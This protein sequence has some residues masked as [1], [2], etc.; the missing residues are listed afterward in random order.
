MFS[1]IPSRANSDYLSLLTFSFMAVSALA[2]EPSLKEACPN[3]SLLGTSFVKWLLSALAGQP[4]AAVRAIAKQHS[5]RVNA[6]V[7]SGPRKEPSSD[8]P[9]DGCPIR[10]SLRQPAGARRINITSLPLP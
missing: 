3:S 8:G 7:P 4:R 1:R 6:L 9:Q 10:T 2:A 5:A